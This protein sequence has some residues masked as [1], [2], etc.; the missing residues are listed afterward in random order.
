MRHIEIFFAKKCKFLVENLRLRS[1]LQAVAIGNSFPRR[2][3][4][5]LLRK[6]AA[7]DGEAL[8]LGVSGKAER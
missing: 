5:F 1:A 6:W 8:R 4:A 3:A 7:H 2:A